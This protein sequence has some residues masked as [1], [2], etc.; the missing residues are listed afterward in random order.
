MRHLRTIALVLLATACAKRSYVASP[1]IYSPGYPAGAIATDWYYLG[2]VRD[3]DEI[4]K[5]IDDLTPPT[6]LDHLGR[7]PVK[8]VTLVTLG[9]DNKVV[10]GTEVGPKAMQE[11]VTSTIDTVTD[12]LERLG[13]SWDQTTRVALFH[14]HDIPGLWGPATLGKI[15]NAIRRG[16]LVFR[17]R[18]PIVGGEV[19]LEARAIHREI[20]LSVA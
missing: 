7:F 11:R 6:I 14:V 13:L 12:T 2:R 5:S 1:S 18:P 17:A 20:V 16:V 3:F 8:D 4:Q 10:A 15:G 19:E 9:P